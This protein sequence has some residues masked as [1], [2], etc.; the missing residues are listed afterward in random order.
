[1]RKVALVVMAVFGIGSFARV[2]AQDVQVSPSNRTISVLASETLRVDPDLAIATV[3][4]SNFGATKEAAYSENLRAAE[5]ITKALFDA[6]LSKEE[7]QTESLQLSAVDSPNHDWTA[8][9]RQDRKFQAEQSWKIRLKVSDAQKIV[10]LAVAA[11][12]T[13]V[14][15]VQWVVADVH[16]LEAR[17]SSA[18]LEKARVLAEQIAKQMGVKLGVLLYATNWQPQ[19]LEFV[20]RSGLTTTVTV[21]GEA[22]PSLVLFPRKV[23]KTGTVSAIFAIE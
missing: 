3:G 15:P 22:Q 14:S 13:D 21:S 23:E 6:G 19:D 18:A 10:D 20:T 7:V 12:A 2:S 8:K 9:E 16:A 17:A 4:Y 1:V 5:K 11:G